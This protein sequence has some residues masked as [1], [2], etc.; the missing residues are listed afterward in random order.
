MK[1]CV[2]GSGYVGLTQAAC[3]AESGHNVYCVDIDVQRIEHLQQGLVPF[4]EPELLNLVKAGIATGNLIFLTDPAAAINFAEVIFIAVGTPLTTDGQADLSALV[5]VVKSVAEFTPADTKKILVNKSTSPVGTV[6]RLQVMLQQTGSVEQR[7]CIQVVANPEFLREGSAVNDCRHPERVI[8]GSDDPEAIEVLRKL[9]APY[10]LD[11][12]SFMVMDPCSAELVKYA[13]NCMLATRISFMNEMANLA[14]QLG[15]DIKKVRLGVAADTRI[16]PQFLQPGCGF[17]GSCLPKDL[18]VMQQTGVEMGIH[19]QVINAVLEV[20]ER[21][22]QRLFHMISLHFHGDLK[23]KTF[24]LWGLAFKPNT[25]DLREA[26]SLTLIDQLL[27]AGACIQAFDP[28]AMPKARSLYFNQPRLIMS[29]SAASALE[30]ANALVVVTEWPAFQTTDLQ[31]IKMC[32]AEPVVFDGRN[33]FEPSEMVTAGF[34]YYSIGR[35]SH[36]S[37]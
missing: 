15:A 17:G 35:A 4:F 23:G 27:E 1:V 2:F 7:A 8:I 25:D 13:A 6:N 29:P 32:L 16:G 19:T 21:Q 10:C 20:N 3:L 9:Y 12:G 22:K 28:V 36:S 34:T 18:Q 11:Q 30:G 5:S 24:A 33:F 31:S 37:K 26:S 14:E